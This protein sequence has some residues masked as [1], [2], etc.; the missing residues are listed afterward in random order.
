VEAANQRAGQ[1]QQQVAELTAKAQAADASARQ[2]EQL[3]G[4]VRELGKE[5]EARKAAGKVGPRA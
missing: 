3:Q 2:V 4:R 1:L 5:L